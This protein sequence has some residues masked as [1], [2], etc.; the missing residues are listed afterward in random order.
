MKAATTRETKPPGESIYLAASGAEATSINIE[1]LF[2]G[3]RER[4]I[5]YGPIF[6]N[7]LD[8]RASGERAITNFKIAEIACEEHDY[9]LH[10][11]TLDSILQASFSSLLKGMDSDTIVLPRSIGSI[12]VP[13]DLKR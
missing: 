7:L 8:S 9:V 10:P 4:G 13:R 11:T 3:L 6:Q 5:Y 1:S 12:F 2:S